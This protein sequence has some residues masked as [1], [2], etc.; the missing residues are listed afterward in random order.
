MRHLIYT[1]V[2]FTTFIQSSY[3]QPIS[4]YILNEIEPRT[5]EIIDSVLM[6][7]DS[8]SIYRE[9]LGLEDCQYINYWN[10]R[11]SLIPEKDYFNLINHKSPIIRFHSY[12]Y[13]LD[14]KLPLSKMEFIN[15]HLADLEYVQYVTS[16]YQLNEITWK[17][18]ENK[19]ET[20]WIKTGP[21][22]KPL[23]QHVIEAAN[24]S[25]NELEILYRS[26][27]KKDLN[28]KEFPLSQLSLTESN[29]SIIKSLAHQ[30]NTT[31][32]AMLAEYQ[33]EENQDFLFNY[34]DSVFY[35]KT[36]RENKRFVEHS[37]KYD[38]P[39]GSIDR[40]LKFYE[41]LKTSN[42]HN[43]HKYVYKHYAKNNTPIR[44]ELMTRLL[45]ESS[46][47]TEQRRKEI[48]KNI[49][50]LL[51]HVPD[52]ELIDFRI[53]FW[54]KFGR[55]KC[56]SFR[57]I[58]SQYPDV[59]FRI[60]NAELDRLEY[61]NYNSRHHINCL[62]KFVGN[63]V[64]NNLSPEKYINWALISK[65]Q[66]LPEQALALSSIYSFPSSK[67]YVL[68]LMQSDNSSIRFRRII[69]ALVEFK[70]SEN[71][72]EEIR[73]WVKPYRESEKSSKYAY[74]LEENLKKMGIE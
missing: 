38:Y 66:D 7:S 39:K 17:L 35:L 54:E 8:T 74:P 62:R 19:Y 37:V 53:E 9:D 48:Y 71:E 65:D 1:F 10:K 13:I 64:D 25:K 11:K 32:I 63:I 70:L 42:S 43:I 33:K 41:E 50:S 23:I 36:N 45:L 30:K 5:N 21:G 16:R 31:A 72:K 18:Y 27:I 20:R 14:N 59:A 26:I 67:V 24:F 57:H 69:D 4:E 52:G 51:W 60:A 49:V 55:L 68:N 29:Y 47:A 12:I 58:K 3:A 6:L 28:S 73:E 34:L 46:N 22:Y 40:F 56:S 61:D 15:Y 44:K 2:L